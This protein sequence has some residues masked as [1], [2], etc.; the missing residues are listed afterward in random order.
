MTECVQECYGMN[1]VCFSVNDVD[2]KFLID[3]GASLCILKYEHI[4]K[5]VNVIRD[6][7]KIKGVGGVLF[8]EGYVYLKLKTQQLIFEQKFYVF[9]N[10]SCISNGI[11]GKNFL[12]RYKCLIDFKSN[13]L[14]LT[15]HEKSVRMALRTARRA[16]VFTI[17]ARCEKIQYIE[18]NFKSDCIIKSEELCDG[19]FWRG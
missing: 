12:S 15:T 9:K 7:L 19:V 8:S 6:K 11:I 13:Q 14:S 16:E 1:E 3:T 2:L 10:L 5:N 4:P 18:T 17:P